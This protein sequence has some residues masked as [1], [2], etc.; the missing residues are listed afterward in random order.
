MQLFGLLLIPIVIG[1]IGFFASKGK[2]HIKEL[3]VQVGASLI[4]IG[5]GYYIALSYRMGDTE[6]W[7]GVIAKKWRDTGSCCHSYPCNPHPCN[8][9]DK[10]NCSTC[11]D[12]CY[13]HGSDKTWNA[14][15]S[16]GEPAYY[17]GCGRPGASD[18]ARWQAIIVGEPTSVEHSYE[19]PIKG[20]PDS[21]LRRQGFAEKFGAALPEYPKVYD[22][23]RAIKFLTPGISVPG[24]QDLNARLSETNAKLG[25]L[26]KVNI[27]TVVTGQSD[28]QFAEALREHWLGGKKNDIVVVIGAPRF[29]QI[30]WV[31]IISWTKSEDV[32]VDLRHRLLDLKEFDGP[33]AIKIIQEEVFGKFVHRSMSDFEYL[34]STVEPSD[35][36]F[37]TLFSIALALS[38]GLQWYFWKN[39]P[40]NTETRR[41]R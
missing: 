4:I 29:P 41:W 20:N 33:K 10:G 11:W 14:V 28:P 15:T 34:K 22:L 39:D 12:T 35:F 19:N 30:A 8:C 26:K 36:A 16:N 21:I 38:I 7:N 24:I 31:D 2:V 3:G 40:F 32:K 1:L 23:Y 18:P 6:H 9:D 27:I 13:E 25:A 37:W 5:I 17:Q